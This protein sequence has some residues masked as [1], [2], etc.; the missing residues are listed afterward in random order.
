VNTMFVKLQAEYHRLMAL[1]AHASPE[2][3]DRRQAIAVITTEVQMGMLTKNQQTGT[4]ND[5]I[6][7]AKAWLE[8]MDAIYDKHAKTIW[9][10]DDI[11]E[12]HRIRKHI[13]EIL[14]G[15]EHA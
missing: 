13:V 8:K 14:H 3:K 2:D 9:S 4:N 15:L 1:G 6:I 11:V 12:A 7:A 10:A 5:T